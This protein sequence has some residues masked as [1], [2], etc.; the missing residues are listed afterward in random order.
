MKFL[1]TIQKMLRGLSSVII[2]IDTGVCAGALPGTKTEPLMQ[3]R[4]GER[5]ELYL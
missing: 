3:C 1:L 5:N 4:N 2:L